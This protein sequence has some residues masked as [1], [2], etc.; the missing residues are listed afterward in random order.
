VE[1]L[2][3]SRL[4]LGVLRQREAAPDLKSFHLGR[5]SYALFGATGKPGLPLAIATSERGI[6]ATLARLGPPALRCETFPQVAQAVR[7]GRY[8]GVLPTFARS[9]LP[10]PQFTLTSVPTL[11]SAASPLTLSWRARTLELRPRAVKRLHSA[12][13]AALRVPM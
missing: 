7:T 8:A 3:A 2:L 11:E 13:K 4:D 5:V 9:A 10:T 12:L 1:G 6:T